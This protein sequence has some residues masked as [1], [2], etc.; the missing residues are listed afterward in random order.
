MSDRPT[1]D[2]ASP[3]PAS[4]EAAN[5][6][7][8]GPEATLPEAPVTDRV[9][10]GYGAFVMPAIMLAVAGYLIFGLVTMEVVESDELLGP[11][12][13]PWAAAIAMIVLAV[14]YAVDIWRRPGE[15]HA[16]DASHPTP[17]NWRTLGLA[18]ASLVVFAIILEPVGWLVSGAVL[19]FGMTTALGWGEAAARRPLFNAVLALGLS[20]AV[21]LIFAGLLGL[22]LPPGLLLGGQ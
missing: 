5:P 1:P 8:T 3:D 2:P 9:T 17:V 20:A 7:A 12:A 15:Q 22:P 4:P 13:M 11:T 19:F 21:Q 16:G 6:E 14:I 10:R 18:V